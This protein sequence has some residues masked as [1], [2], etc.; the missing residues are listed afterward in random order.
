MKNVKQSRNK[1]F[2]T[3]GDKW[4]MAP[5]AA[6]HKTNYCRE[7]MH[8]FGKSKE[9]DIRAWSVKTRRNEG[10]VRTQNTMD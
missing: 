2:T 3:S 9:K 1:L 8:K 5:S 6:P 7:L 10:S 4:S